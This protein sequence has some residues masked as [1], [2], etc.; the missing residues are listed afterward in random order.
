MFFI[1]SICSSLRWS[2]KLLPKAF[3]WILTKWLLK[4]VDK[5][6]CLYICD[7]GLFYIL[8]FPHFYFLS[9]SIIFYTFTNVIWMFRNNCFQSLELHIF[10]TW[11]NL[12]GSNKKV[13]QISYTLPPY[14]FWGQ[15]I[16]SRQ[17]FLGRGSLILKHSDF[18]I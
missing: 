13:F 2:C 11:I 18:D 1:A 3:L 7:Q 5:V 14:H 15:E 9:I 6:R 16:Q 12:K 4:R 8:Y 10:V 17:F